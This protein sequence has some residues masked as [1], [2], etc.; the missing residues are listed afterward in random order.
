[1]GQIQMCWSGATIPPRNTQASRPSEERA[2]SPEEEEKKEENKVQ[3]SLPS[4][5][6]EELGAAQGGGGPPADVLE[7]AKDA[8][9]AAE[10][11]AKHLEACGTAAEVCSTASI[12]I[13]VDQTDASSMEGRSSGILIALEGD[14]G[15]QKPI[16]IDEADDDKTEPADVKEPGNEIEETENAAN[17]RRVSIT[18]RILKSKNHEQILAS[19]TESTET[20]KKMLEE[21]LSEH[22]QLVHE[23]SSMEGSSVPG[24]DKENEGMN[25]KEISEKTSPVN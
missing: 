14:D 8:E 21:L 11:V 6:D 10:A 23:L 16:E 19:I 12:E 18:E 24:S 4:D 7:G 17:K 20:R 13:K 3:I 15:S 9:S 2:D 22:Q 5:H 1:M 25:N